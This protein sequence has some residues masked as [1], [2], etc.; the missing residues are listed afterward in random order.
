MPKGGS[1]DEFFLPTLTVMIYFHFIWLIYHF[2][3]IICTKSCMILN[4]N[5]AYMRLN[6]MLCIS[7]YIKNNGSNLAL[8]AIN[9]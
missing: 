2:K 4:I 1:R 5:E 8:T 3:R 9:F 7:L 6:K